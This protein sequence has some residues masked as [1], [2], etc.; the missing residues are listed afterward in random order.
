MQPRALQGAACLQKHS[1]AVPLELLR[2]D[3]I[4]LL[5]KEVCYCHQGLYLITERHQREARDAGESLEGAFWRKLASPLGWEWLLKFSF[6]CSPGLLFF[7]HYCYLSLRF[8]W[9]QLWFDFVCA[10]PPCAGENTGWKMLRHDGATT[11]TNVFVLEKSL[12]VW[13]KE[14]VVWQQ[15]E[16]TTQSPVKTEVLDRDWEKVL[17]VCLANLCLV[18][19]AKV[20]TQRPFFFADI[21]NRR[22]N[23]NSQRQNKVWL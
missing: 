15:R 16:K 14:S 11:G 4:F 9:R 2:R 17:S 12:R 22:K 20:V 6:L 18:P 23:N 8:F 3:S 5:F 7:F 21:N 10:V 1:L 13:W 19:K